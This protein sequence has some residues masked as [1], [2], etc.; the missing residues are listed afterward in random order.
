MM[1]NKEAV[2]ALKDLQ[3]IMKNKRPLPIKNYKRYANS[4]LYAIN[5]I[6]V[7]NCI[8]GEINNASDQS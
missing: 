2:N 1:T 7:L 6:T 4:L 8:G 3:D 5:A